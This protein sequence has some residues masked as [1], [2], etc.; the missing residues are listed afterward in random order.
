MFYPRFFIA[1]MLLWSGLAIAQPAPTDPI[2]AALFPPE[3]VMRHQQVR[4][5]VESLSSQKVTGKLRNPTRFRANCRTDCVRGPSTPVRVNGKPT[6]SPP[7][8]WPSISVESR[9]ISSRN[10]RLRIVSSG[11]A[12]I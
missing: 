3:L 5:A 6:M 8:L 4:A 7:T 9:V 12:I 2:G 10:R 11:V 1:G